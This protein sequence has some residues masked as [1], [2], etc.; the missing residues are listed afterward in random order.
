MAELDI[1]PAERRRRERRAQGV[2]NGRS[3][4]I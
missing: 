1:H 3:G 4:E 2:W